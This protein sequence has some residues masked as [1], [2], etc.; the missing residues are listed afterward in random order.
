MEAMASDF[1][2][3]WVSFFGHWALPALIA[4]VGVLTYG[5]MWLVRLWF[6]KPIILKPAKGDALDRI[7]ALYCLNR[8]YGEDDESFRRRIYQSTRISTDRPVGVPKVPA[9][10]F[11]GEAWPDRDS[12][13]AHDRE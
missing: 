8:M 10:R 3:W 9:T 5:A 2:E 13:G 12:K 4:S 1:M 11:D 6:G 7:G